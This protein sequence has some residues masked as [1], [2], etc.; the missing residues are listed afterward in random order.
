MFRISTWENEGNFW[1]LVD[2]GGK[3]AG[4]VNFTPLLDSVTPLLGRTSSGFIYYYNEVLNNYETIQI[5]SASL[6]CNLINYIDNRGFYKFM[7][8]N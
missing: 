2:D 3:I 8:R 7:I 6:D 4:A 1:E 5:E